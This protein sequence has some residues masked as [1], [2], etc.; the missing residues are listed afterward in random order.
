MNHTTAADLAVDDLFIQWVK[1]PTPESTTYW[2]NW[3]KENPDK[4][5][6]VAE[7]RKMVL[8][9]SHDD[10]QEHDLDHDL[11]AIWHRLSEARKSNLSHPSEN[12]R[13]IPFKFWQ[14]RSLWAAAAVGLLLLVSGALLLSRDRVKMIE[15]ATTYGERRTITLSDSSVVVLNANSRITLP[16]RWS[17]N[18]PREV[19]LTGEAFF[20]VTHKVNKQK[21]IVT[22]SEGIH[23]EVLG[24]EFN[25][26]ERANENKIVL[27]NGKVRLNIEN[28]SETKTLEMIPGEMISITADTEITR[29]QVKPELYTSWT[30]DKIYFDNS[31]LDEI[32]TM[33]QQHYGYAVTFKDAHLRKLKMNAYLDIKGPDD[34]LNTIS[35][36]FEVDVLRQNNQITIS[37]RQL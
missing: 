9:L 1:Y 29:K 36:T 34:I 18:D 35:E 16:S 4:E 19:Q 30:N 31:T 2:E 5:A 28:G 20:S 25:L 17:D 6:I 3:I 26:S 37:S 12:G 32:A 11:D 15:Y 27:A 7:A 14:Q 33:L 8:F 24:T 10:E 22:T 13:I 23:V 21:F